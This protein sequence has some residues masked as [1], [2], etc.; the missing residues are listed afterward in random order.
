VTAPMA[1]LGPPPALAP[2][3]ITTGSAAAWESAARLSGGGLYAEEDEE[4]DAEVGDDELS[5]QTD[6]ATVR[7]PRRRRC[8]RV[9]G[10]AAAV[11]VLVTLVVTTLRFL[12]TIGAP[13][14]TVLSAMQMQTDCERIF[15]AGPRVA[16][17]K[18]DG[19]TVTR[20]LITGRL[21]TL[22]WRVDTDEFTADTV[23]GQRSFQNIVAYG[24][25]AA[26]TKNASL[27]VLAAHYDSKLFPNFE[28]L[29]ATDSVASVVILLDVAANLTAQ[30][31]PSQQPIA[32]VFFDGEEAFHRWTTTDSLYGSR[33]LAARWAADHTLDRIDLFVLLDLLGTRDATLHSYFDRTRD[34]YLRLAGIERTL[35]GGGLAKRSG[36]L[37]A[38]DSKGLRIGDD[39]EPFLAHGVPIV[40]LIPFPFPSVWHTPADGPNALDWDTMYDLALIL[41]TFA[42]TYNFSSPDRLPPT[43]P[44]PLQRPPLP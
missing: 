25:P 6:F 3:P 17:S 32:L 4:I 28:F 38:E 8:A 40:H 14:T 19:V 21:R 22:G 18:S 33:H 44:P 11:S 5:L 29:G 12:G 35:R 15:G 1:G 36:A 43:V 9:L 13:N 24:P 34:R 16:G 2:P 42:R 27:L 41:T 20:G 37:F 26:D 23:I 39:H 30:T 7:R 10:S 31:T